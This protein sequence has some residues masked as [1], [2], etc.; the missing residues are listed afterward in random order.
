MTKTL[1][2]LLIALSTAPAAAAPT[3]TV[4]TSVRTADLDLSSESGQRVLDQ[5]LAQAAIQLCGTAWDSDVPGKNEVRRCRAE[6]K[7]RFAAER[8]RRIAAALAK[9][10]GLAAR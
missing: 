2:V 6:V 4:S 1:A 8:D 3:A 10:E 5:R 7:A 9:P